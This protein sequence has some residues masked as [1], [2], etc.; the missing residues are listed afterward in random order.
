METTEYS[1]EEI[2]DWQELK[3][4]IQDLAGLKIH[5][6]IAWASN[7]QEIKDLYDQMEYEI[8]ENGNQPKALEH[9]QEIKTRLM[10][11]TNQKMR[12]LSIK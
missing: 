7:D 4:T 5:Q 9:S 10:M 3:W 6:F 12:R 8:M 2:S 11:N 1:R